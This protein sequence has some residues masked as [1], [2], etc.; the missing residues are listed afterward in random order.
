MGIN[1]AIA[2][3]PT[4]SGTQ[5]GSIGLGFAIPINSARMIATELIKTGKAV[6]ASIGLNSRAVTDGARLGAYLVQVLPAGPADQA[7]LKAGDVI[8]LADAT[9][10]VS[11]DEL[12]L[13]VGQH[14]PGD[15]LTVRYYRGNVE[16]SAS[17]T[18]GAA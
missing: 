3:L 4:T 16:S 13:V 10:I 7:G 14:K 5:N 15:V 18:L 1:S 17:V 12:S 8:T 2:T 11:A 6:H 9:L